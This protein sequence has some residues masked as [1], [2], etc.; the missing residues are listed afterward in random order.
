MHDRI[1]SPASTAFMLFALPLIIG[2]QPKLSVYTVDDDAA[3]RAIC[4]QFNA[5]WLAGNSDAVLALYAPD[6]VLIP[7]HGDE[8]VAG[9]ESIRMFWFNPDYPPTKVLKM[10]NTIVEADGSGD[11]AFVRGIGYLEYEYQNQRYSNRG[12]FLQI[13]KRGSNGWKIFRH[14]WNDPLAP[15]LMN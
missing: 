1:A 5:A 7:H 3:V 11:M 15:V 9:K 13:F 10:E 14:I 2:C 6:A 4:Q 12:N 8:P